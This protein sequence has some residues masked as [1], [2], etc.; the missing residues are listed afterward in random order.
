M[1][2]QHGK[3]NRGSASSVGSSSH[4]NKLTK[5]GQKQKAKDIRLSSVSANIFTEH[6]GECGFRD[7]T[8]ECG[9]TESNENPVDGY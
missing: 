3:E 6:S 8:P 1:G 9:L 5:H 2:A 7:R 4:G